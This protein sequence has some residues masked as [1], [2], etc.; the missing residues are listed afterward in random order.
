MEWP[1]FHY[2]P[3]EETLHGFFSNTVGGWTYEENKLFENALA[4]IEPTGS[5]AF[6]ESVA[7]KIPWRSV[8]EIKDHYQALIDD[9]N[10]IETGNFPVPDY[11]VV[12]E[13]EKQDEM[14]AN[15][16]KDG[17]GNEAKTASGQQRRRGVPWTEEEHQLFLMGLNKYGKGDWRSISRYYVITKTPTQV[18]SHAQK[19]FRRQTSSTPVDR[20]R[21]SI[22]D[23]QTVNPAA[24]LITSSVP[25][26]QINYLPNVDEAI[27]FTSCGLINPMLHNNFNGGILDQNPMFLPMSNSTFPSDNPVLDQTSVG[28]PGSYLFPS[29]GDQQ[30][31]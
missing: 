15:N 13:H 7:S 28:Y 6:F 8:E 22:H 9:L 20:R 1:D 18:A 4:E 14:E 24:T 31:G 29:L 21:P 23:I 17:G 5:P 3:L 26:T 25:R 27:S 19:Y 10:M 2:S 30:W 12:D 16:I 11:Q